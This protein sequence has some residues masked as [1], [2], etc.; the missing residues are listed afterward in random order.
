[1]NWKRPMKHE[2]TKKRKISVK[3]SADDKICLCLSGENFQLL[4]S[5]KIGDLC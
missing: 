1:M 2:M 4:Y 3:L 5:K